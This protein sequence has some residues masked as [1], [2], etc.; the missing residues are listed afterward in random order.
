MVMY[1][2]LKSN[3]P[4]VM[5]ISS[6]VYSFQFSFFLSWPILTSEYSVVKL[7]STNKLFKFVSICVIICLNSVDLCDNVNLTIITI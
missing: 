1:I 4:N 3:M 2:L 6:L 7:Y 5:C